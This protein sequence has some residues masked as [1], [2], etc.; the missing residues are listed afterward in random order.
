VLNRNKTLDEL[1]DD[2]ARDDDIETKEKSVQLYS[3]K[4]MKNTTSP[5]ILRTYSESFTNAESFYQTTL[6]ENSSVSVDQNKVNTTN[7]R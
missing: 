5:E 3:L 4:L 6:A 1:K 2:I 7:M